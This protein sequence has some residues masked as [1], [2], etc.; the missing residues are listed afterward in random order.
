MIISQETRIK[1]IFFPFQ[2]GHEYLSSL[3]IRFAQE[4]RVDH[5]LIADI[6]REIR[7]REEDAIYQSPDLVSHTA[8]SSSGLIPHV[9]ANV[10]RGSSGEAYRPGIYAVSS[11]MYIGICDRTGSGDGVSSVMD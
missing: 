10:K 5:D 1:A 6:L 7:Q 2:N 11:G 9:Y 3:A 8:E 4:F